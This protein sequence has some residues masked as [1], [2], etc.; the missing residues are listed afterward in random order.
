MRFEPCPPAGS[1]QV[2]SWT[3]RT[4]FQRFAAGWPE[5]KVRR[6]LYDHTTHTGEEAELEIERAI[7]RAPAYLKNAHADAR[8]SGLRRKTKKPKIDPAAV[9]AVLVE[10]SRRVNVEA[11]RQLSPLKQLTTRDV[12]PL[13]YPDNPLIWAAYSVKPE[14]LADTRRVSDWLPVAHKLQYIAP[15]P[16][17]SRRVPTGKFSR[18]CGVNTGPRRFIV[19]ESDH[20]TA[21]EQAAILLHIGRFV[22][23]VLA[24]HSGNKS[25]HG[26]VNV[27][28]RSPAWCEALADKAMELRADPQPARTASQAVRMPGGRHDNGRVQEI[29]FCNPAAMEVRP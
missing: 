10:S 26:W 2:N 9:Q 25:I 1:G 16:M 24:V 13:L 28:G 8:R 7:E 21:D 6:Y 12:L 5:E 22:P 19:L 20:G 17:I 27:A 15:N 18:R 29:L 3:F 11:L 23:L 4:A 14:L